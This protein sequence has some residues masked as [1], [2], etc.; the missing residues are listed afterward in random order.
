M[1]QGRARDFNGLDW[2]QLSPLGPIDTSWWGRVT[3]RYVGAILPSNLHANL[4]QPVTLGAAPPTPGLR[5]ELAR[6]LR[7]RGKVP[8][9]QNLLA[10]RWSA[11]TFSLNLQWAVP[12]AEPG[13]RRPEPRGEGVGPDDAVRLSGQGPPTRPPIQ[14]PASQPGGYKPLVAAPTCHTGLDTLPVVPY[15]CRHTR[16]RTCVVKPASDPTPSPSGR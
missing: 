16:D 3:P 9:P 2:G 6:F 1:C 7:G 8:R 5:F 15:N 13:P 12:S 14:S 10:H 4:R 11:R